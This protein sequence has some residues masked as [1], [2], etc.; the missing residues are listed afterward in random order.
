M[1]PEESDAGCQLERTVPLT[2]VAAKPRGA[3]GAVRSTVTTAPGE[4]STALLPAVSSAR[5][6]YANCPSPTLVSVKESMSAG[7]DAI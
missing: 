6:T 4:K 5:T 1:M 7:T 2:T 3:D